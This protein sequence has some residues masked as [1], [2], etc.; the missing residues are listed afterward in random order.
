LRTRVEWLEESLG[1]LLLEKDNAARGLA[2]GGVDL[3]AGS[4]ERNNCCVTFSDASP[5]LERSLLQ[6]HNCCVR[7]RSSKD[8]LSHDHK[9]RAALFVARCVFGILVLMIVLMFFAA[10]GNARGMGVHGEEMGG[11]HG[12]EMVGAVDMD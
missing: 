1:R 11:V 8:R 5:D 6:G 7:F 3:A 10:R 4:R 9:H 12:E 2:E